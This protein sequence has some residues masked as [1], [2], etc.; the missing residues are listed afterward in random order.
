[1]AKGKDLQPEEIDR[2]LQD[3]GGELSASGCTSVRVMMVGGAYMLLT[4]GNRATTQDI[5]VFPLNF[6]SSAHPDQQTKAILKAIA[7]VAQRNRLKRDWF[8]DAAFG[9]IGELQPPEQQLTL[10]RIYGALEI[11]LPPPEFILAVKIFGYRDRDYNDVMALLAQLNVQSR[12]RAQ[13]ILDSY[14]ERKTQEEYRTHI[15]LDDFFEGE[16]EGR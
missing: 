8:N 16:A 7:S 15:T 9:I 3:L 1:M 6:A 10:W 12:A 11:Y 13:Q 14:I 2:L 5:D 4:L